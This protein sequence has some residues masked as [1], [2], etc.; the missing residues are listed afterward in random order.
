MADDP[1]RIWRFPLGWLRDKGDIGRVGVRCNFCQ[2]KADWP[3][4]EMIERY[5]ASTWLSEI[6][7]RWRCAACG[8]K[9]CTPYTIGKMGS[10]R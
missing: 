9:D 8:K 6:W 5:G 4:D 10:P 1:P 2:H 7:R 3:I